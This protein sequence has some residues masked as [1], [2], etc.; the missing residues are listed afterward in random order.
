MPSG[1]VLRGR[2]YFL[3]KYN[4]FAGKGNLPP[5]QAREDNR[6]TSPPTICRE[7]RHQL[8]ERGAQ[9]PA[10]A[11]TPTSATSL[12]DLLRGGPGKDEV[13]ISLRGL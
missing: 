13:G 3:W 2:C 8:T 12:P 11:P 6:A 10:P 4:T 1:L 7:S 9:N 5:G